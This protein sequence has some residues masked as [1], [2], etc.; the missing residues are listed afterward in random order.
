MICK[1][2]EYFSG[3]ILIFYSVIFI[4]CG[5]AFIKPGKLVNNV[6]LFPKK[7]GNTAKITFLVTKFLITAFSRN[8]NLKGLPHNQISSLLCDEAIAVYYQCILKHAIK[9]L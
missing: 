2:V 4:G 7:V 8:G 5:K 1:H 6:G 3:K 9:R